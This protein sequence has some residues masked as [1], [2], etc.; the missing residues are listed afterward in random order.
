MARTRNEAKSTAAKPPTKK[1][2][3]PASPDAV[4]PRPKRGPFSLKG[5][6]KRKEKEDAKSEEEQKI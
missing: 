3:R 5:E 1:G 2:A 4:I 6:Q